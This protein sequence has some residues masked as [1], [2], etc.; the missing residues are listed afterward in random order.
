MNPEQ[1]IHNKASLSTYRTHLSR[2]IRSTMILKGLKY[3]DLSARLEE[4]GVSL[5]ADNLR[6]KVSKGMFAAD[7]MLLLFKIMQVEDSALLDIMKLVEQ[8]DIE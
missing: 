5:T 8:A 4:Y 1:S 3:D 2:Y 6:S 7:L